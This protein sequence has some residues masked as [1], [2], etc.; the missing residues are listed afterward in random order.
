[1]ITGMCTTRQGLCYGLLPSHSLYRVQ[2]EVCE[3]RV[4]SDH[5]LDL[6]R[7]HLVDESIRVMK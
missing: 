7:A 5:I 6:Q 2:W 4:E 3:Y 1:M